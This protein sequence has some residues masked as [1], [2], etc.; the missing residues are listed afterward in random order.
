MTLQLDHGIPFQS[1]SV[2]RLPRAVMV[3]GIAIS[4]RLVDASKTV[5]ML[6][7]G[8]ELSTLNIGHE[9]PANS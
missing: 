4:T 3:D 2:L 8:G 5:R 1:F 9:R 7:E 6:C